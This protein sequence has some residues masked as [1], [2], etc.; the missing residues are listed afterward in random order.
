MLSRVKSFIKDSKGP[1][2]KEG[3][4]IDYTEVHVFENGFLYGVRNVKA[5]D[6][7]ERVKEVEDGASEE[8]TYYH[9]GYV[10]GNRIKIAGAGAFIGAGAKILGLF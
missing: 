5:Q 3:G 10:A 4:Y 9:W 7:W 6:G 1:F 2:T 8:Y